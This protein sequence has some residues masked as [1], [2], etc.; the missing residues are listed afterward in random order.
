MHT[1]IVVQRKLSVEGSVI[2]KHDI[3]MLDI[4]IPHLLYNFCVISRIELHTIVENIVI[5]ADLLYGNINFEIELNIISILSSKSD[6]RLINN[7]FDLK[8]LILTVELTDNGENSGD[9]LGIDLLVVCTEV[10]DEVLSR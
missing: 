3:H 4:G 1:H 9:P 5:F 10:F 6:T 7:Q 8:L 2:S